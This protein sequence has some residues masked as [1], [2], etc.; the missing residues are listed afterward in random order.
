[1]K[2]HRR[3]NYPFTFFIVGVHLAALC[4]PVFSKD[5]YVEPLLFGL[6]VSVP[7]DLANLFNRFPI[8]GAL[9]LILATGLSFI[10]FFGVITSPFGYMFGVP[11][12]KY[13]LGDYALK[14]PEMSSSRSVDLT[15]ELPS[16]PKSSFLL[17][18]IR[19]E[20]GSARTLFSDQPHQ[21]EQECCQTFLYYFDS[22]MSYLDYWEPGF[23]EKWKPSISMLRTRLGGK[24]G[25]E[26][27]KTVEST[28]NSQY[29]PDYI[30][31]MFFLISENEKDVRNPT[32][33]KRIICHAHGAL[34]YMPVALL[35]IYHKF[36]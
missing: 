22:I 28:L 36:R 35:K 27:I 23:L 17:D 12:E 24:V 33:Q 9:S 2:K 34:P 5:E 26:V 21:S 30:H 8:Q 16:M 3:L 14:H 32:C 31:S 4:V 18:Y 25:K 29:T 7:Y 6:K 11:S 1:M 13:I 20:K 19:S 15:T 10:L